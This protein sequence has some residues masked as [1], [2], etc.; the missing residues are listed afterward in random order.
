MFFNSIYL[1]TSFWGLDIRFC[2][3]NVMDKPPSGYIKDNIITNCVLI[4]QLRM[5]VWN[6]LDK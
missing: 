4:L 3:M 2:F 5:E 1:K 6:V